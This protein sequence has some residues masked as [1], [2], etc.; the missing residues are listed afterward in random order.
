MTQAEFDKL[1][2][3]ATDAVVTVLKGAEVVS[4][5]DVAALY[6]IND[7]LEPILKN[8]ADVGVGP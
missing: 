3:D 2:D 1:L 5:D 8:I 6:R 4:D 7:A